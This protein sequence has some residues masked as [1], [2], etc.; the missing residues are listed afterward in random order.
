MRGCEGGFFTGAY[1]Y[2]KI[3][4]IGRSIDY[5]YDDLARYVGVVSDCRKDI[6]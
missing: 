6:V 4:G 1:D 3:N 5:E 2:V